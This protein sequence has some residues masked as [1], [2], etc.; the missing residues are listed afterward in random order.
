MRAAQVGLS[1][2]GRRFRGRSRNGMSDNVEVDVD[3]IFLDKSELVQVVGA[4]LCGA[5]RRRSVAWESPG[6]TRNVSLFGPAPEHVE[7]R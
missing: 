6:L 3:G 4:T 2:K 5:Q 1:A 7:D